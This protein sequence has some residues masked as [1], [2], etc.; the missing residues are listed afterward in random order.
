MKKQHPVSSNK[1]CRI[2]DGITHINI[3]SKGKTVLGR[4]LS[5]FAETPFIY[6]G[7][8]F[9]SVEG[10]LFYF[11]TG[12][13][14]FIHLHGN[15]AKKLGD[16]LPCKKIETSKLLKKW[17]LAKLKFNPAIVSMLLD[18]KL[19]FS[20][21][22]FMYGSKI[23]KSLINAEIWRHISEELKKNISI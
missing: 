7:I 19:P 12:D 3:Y 21:Y 18:N 1:F 10:C 20:H 6:D 11:R 5:N 9:R 8:S 16:S 14:R 4:L 13:K 22:Y 15:E 17:F 23:D 2:D